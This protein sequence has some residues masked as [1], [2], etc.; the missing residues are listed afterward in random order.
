MNNELFLQN[1]KCPICLMQVDDPCESGC[2][3]QLFCGKCVKTIKRDICPICRS[4]SCVFRE[5]LF[6]RQFLKKIYIDCPNGCEISLTLADIRMHR[7]ECVEAIYKCSVEGCMYEGKK[8]DAITHFTNI[9]GDIMVVTME[10][11]SKL[12]N[13]YD[14]HSLFDKLQNKDGIFK[15]RTTYDYLLRPYK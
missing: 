11:Y 7:F 6:M 15:Y 9:H 1:L 12:K 13:I 10:N 4:I 2:C 5:N 8:E 14:K 3:G